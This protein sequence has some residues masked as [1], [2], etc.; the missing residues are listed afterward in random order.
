MRVRKR[1]TQNIEKEGRTSMAKIRSLKKMDE[2]E[3]LGDKICRFVN[4]YEKNKGQSLE[5]AALADILISI[6]KIFRSYNEKFEKLEKLNLEHQVAGGA[7]NI[8][9]VFDDPNKKQEERI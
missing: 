3:D 6:K 9:I 5:L 8:K 1:R 7:K 2:T 4:Y